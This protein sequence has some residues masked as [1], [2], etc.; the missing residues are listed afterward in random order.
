MGGSRT[1]PTT[2]LF[3]SNCVISIKT[4][5]SFCEDIVE[6]IVTQKHIPVSMIERLLNALKSWKISLI[7]LMLSLTAL[8]LGAVN[9]RVAQCHQE[10]DTTNMLGAHRCQSCHPQAY[11]A[12]QESA[13]AGAYDRLEPEDRKNA[14]C[15]QCHTSGTASHLQGI[16]CESCHGG[17]RYYTIPEVMV[18]AQ[19]AR[20]VGLRVQRGEKSCLSCHKAPSPK[21]RKFH[22]PT[23]WSKIKHGR[24]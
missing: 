9:L 6:T 1:A 7:V 2:A 12:W 24:K 10:V 13:H 20:T 14:T 4:I 11:K 23:M 3:V 19:L 16:Q 8:S 18:D 17:G 5:T 21:L 22:H 15:L